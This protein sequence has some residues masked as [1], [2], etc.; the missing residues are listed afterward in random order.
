MVSSWSTK[1]ENMAW[2]LNHDG[3]LAQVEKI[4]VEIETVLH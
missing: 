2:E 1:H 3:L 4:G